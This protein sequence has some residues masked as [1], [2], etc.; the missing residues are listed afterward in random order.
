[1]KKCLL[2]VLSLS[3]FALS[4]SANA[5]TIGVNGEV[6]NSSISNNSVFD[7]S[8]LVVKSTSVWDSTRAVTELNTVD[9]DAYPY[10]SPDGL[11]LY[12]T[13][14]SGGNQL[15]VATRAVNDFST[16]FS[17]PQV[18]GT[19]FSGITSSWFTNNQLELFYSSS[20]VIYTA[21][22]T[23][24]GGAFTTPQALTIT[25]FSGFIAGHSLT[26]NKQ[27]LFV[28]NAGTIDAVLHCTNTGGLNYVVDD[29]LD[30]PNGFYG[31]TGQ[32]SKD[33]LSY[34][35][36]VDSLGF[37]KLHKMTRAAFM[38]PFSNLTLLSGSINDNATKNSQPTVT[39]DESVIVFVK[40]NLNTWA[41]NDLYL[42]AATSTV[43]VNELAANNRVNVFPNPANEVATFT[44]DELPVSLSIYDMQGKLMLNE[45]MTNNQYR[46]DLTNFDKGV[47]IYKVSYDNTTTTGKLIVK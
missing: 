18:V 29:T 13:Q 11:S 39:G 15:Y 41:D 4:N 1:M 33:G 46:L 24:I 30:M 44:F 31:S 42:S 35:V 23:T 20:S 43:G 10:I 34:Y 40:N 32:L 8:S 5:Q 14:N 21:T 27:E 7:N 38:D 22:R 6:V 9:A 36:S 28:F 2:S 17:N 37:T 3:L 45:T 47:Y 25:G 26:P 12:Y 19:G 16:P